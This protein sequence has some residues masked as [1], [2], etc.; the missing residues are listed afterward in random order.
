MFSASQQITHAYLSRCLEHS[1]EGGNGGTG[2]AGHVHPSCN[3][4]CHDFFCSF[5]TLA[6]GMPVMLCENRSL[7]IT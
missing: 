4:A 1:Q 3:L 6:R 7:G 2:I 5:V